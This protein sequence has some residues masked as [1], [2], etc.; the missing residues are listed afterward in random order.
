M[1][2]DGIS[3]Y[4]PRGRAQSDSICP[5]KEINVKL[6]TSASVLSL[7]AVLG[8]WVAAVRPAVA[9]DAPA[10]S[11]PVA[12]DWSGAAKHVGETVTVTGPVISTH[13]SN[14]GKS[15]SLNIGKDYP[16]TDRFTIF[17][18]TDKAASADDTYKGKTVTVTGK[19][20]LYKKVP[21]IK[22]DEKDVTVAKP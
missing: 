16:A 7:L 4:D 3:V 5:P 8:F 13:A 17:V 15:V 22:V 1:A 20:V 21:E 9:D 14:G 10:T 18:T 12:I 2:T 11:K 6:T 19:I